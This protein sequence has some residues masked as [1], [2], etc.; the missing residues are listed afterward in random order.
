MATHISHDLLD[1]TMIFLVAEQKVTSMTCRGDGNERTIAQ[2][3]RQVFSK[4]WRYEL[5]Q[6]HKSSKKLGTT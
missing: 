1:P 5:A 2:G 6:D 4:G 3:V